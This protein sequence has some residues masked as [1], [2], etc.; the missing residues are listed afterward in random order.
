MLI[1]LDEGLEGYQAAVEAA[2]LESEETRPVVRAVD[3][4]VL[5]VNPNYELE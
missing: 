1:V 4:R 2:E 5:T 3:Y